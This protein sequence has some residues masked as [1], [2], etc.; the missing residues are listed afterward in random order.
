MSLL[1][2]LAIFALYRDDNRALKVS[3]LNETLNVSARTPKRFK[4]SALIYTT[5]STALKI[6]A[7]YFECNTKSVCRKCF[8]Q[9]RFQD[10]RAAI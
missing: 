3:H 7:K 8:V 2:I 1:S 6:S 9:E 10:V 5:N 4:E